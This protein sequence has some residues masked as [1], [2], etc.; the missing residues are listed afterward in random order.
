MGR[1]GMIATSQ[2]LASAAGLAVLRGGGNAVDAAVTAAAVLAVVEPTMTGV[3]GDL[4]ALVFDAR[5]GELRGLNASG[6]T[7]RGASAAKLQAEG[8]Q[9][10]PLRGPLSVTVPGA[11][12]GWAELL[13]RDGTISLAQALRPAIEYARDGFPV[14]EIVAGQWQAV[15]DVLAADEGAT[16]TFLPA[17]RAPRAG[18]VFANPDLARTLELIGA[19]GAD[20]FYLGSPAR[21]I[22]RRLASDGGLIDEADFAACAADWVDPIRTTFRGC[23]IVELPPNTQGFVVLEMLNIL[24]QDDLRALGHNSAAYLHLVAEAK[25]VAFS[26]RDARLADG[27]HVPAHVLAALISKEYA[28]TRRRQIDPARAAAEVR[29][30]RFDGASGRGGAAEVPAGSGDTVYLTAVDAQGNAVSLIQSLFESFGSGLVVAGT[31]VA[32]HNRGS[33]FVLDPHHPNRLGGNKRPLH[34][35]IPGMVFRAGRPILSFGVMGGDLQPQ[36]HVQ[37]LVNLLEFGMSVQEAGDAARIRHAGDGIA[38]EEG[39]G[40][41][42]RAGLAERG[43]RVC[44][45]PGAFGGYQAIA[46]DREAGVLAG[47]SDPRKDGLAIGF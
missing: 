30:G 33:L 27:V 5:R 15:E 16:A 14:C 11:V 1:R 39:I 9:R 41:E 45:S 13:A 23:E 10:I 38:V 22:C 3:G 25:R 37:V 32:L 42:A 20:A 6:R 2:P 19:G 36:G 8:H 31:G 26:D 35:L 44:E 34:T 21:E 24:E 28:K 29:P 40:A 12:R 18:E 17:G 46:I 7:G 47:G 43:H 4:F